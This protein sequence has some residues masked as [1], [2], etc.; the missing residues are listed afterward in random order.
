M[1]KGIIYGL[2][3]LS[4]LGGGAWFLSQPSL[5]VPDTINQDSSSNPSCEYSC[6]NPDRDCSDFSSHSEAQE[7][8]ECCGFTASNDPMKLDSLGVG[9][10]VACE[11]I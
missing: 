4:A 8:F 3:G 6:D 5:P 10:G 1:K 7:F 9:N 11:S 2:L